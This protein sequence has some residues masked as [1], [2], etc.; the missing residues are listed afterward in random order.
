[1]QAGELFAPSRFYYFFETRNKAA[2]TTYDYK[3]A[4][5]KVS[6][7]FIKQAPGHT[8]NNMGFH[9]SVSFL[10]LL[11]QVSVRPLS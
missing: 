9:E 7:R 2:V 10:L 5:S 6:Q 1:M 11:H 8:D 3:T 4:V